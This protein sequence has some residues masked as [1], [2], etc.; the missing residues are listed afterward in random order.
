M[1]PCVCVCVGVTTP[2]DFVPSVEG[3]E[4]SSE[5]WDCSQGTANKQAK[6][7][8][9]GK[10][11]GREAAGYQASRKRDTQKQLAGTRTH[12]VWPRRLPM[13]CE[14]SP[15]AQAVLSC[16]NTLSCQRSRNL[17][18]HERQAMISMFMCVPM[19]ACS[20]IMLV[21]HMQAWSLS[22]EDHT[23]K[24]VAKLARTLPCVHVGC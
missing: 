19:A 11:H 15:P 14:S 20:S 23:L 10:K 17:F 3:T 6:R 5:H 18:R 16:R 9:K 8:P 24:S 12:M 13:L 4:E 7:P 2:A 22:C 1:P 21:G